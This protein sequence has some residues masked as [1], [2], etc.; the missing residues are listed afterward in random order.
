[1]E[2]PVH[3]E[4]PTMLSQSRLNLRNLLSSKKPD[5]K[6]ITDA[7]EQWH[8]D[9]KDWEGMETFQRAF[10]NGRMTARCVDSDKFEDGDGKPKSFEYGNRQMM[11]LNVTQIGMQKRLNPDNFG[12]K[13]GKRPKYD[14]GL[15][16]L[17]AVLLLPN[18]K[19]TDQLFKQGSDVIFMPLPL[20]DDLQMLYLLSK[21]ARDNKN[22]ALT[23]EYEKIRANMTHIKYADIK[24]Q[25]IVYLGQSDDS[26]KEHIRY[27][28][29]KSGSASIVK[30]K[31]TQDQGNPLNNTMWNALTYKTA[32]GFYKSMY[33]QKLDQHS[34]FEEGMGKHSDNNEVVVAYRRH[35]LKCFPMI[36]VPKDGGGYSVAD[37]EWHP[38]GS[39]SNDGKL[40]K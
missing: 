22:I 40:S 33:K 29:T 19:I 8:H 13:S 2:I 20:E 25:G 31:L 30:G 18:R 34:E 3:T 4:V 11:K 1:M 28:G 37:I 7:A 24:D 9:F 14:L 38:I 23:Q 16:D 27:G 12:T 5:V 32:L 26:G 21:S 15:H 39:L 6:Q 10:E 17:S 35:E 36:G